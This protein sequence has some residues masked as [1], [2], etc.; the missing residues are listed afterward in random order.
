[1]HVLNVIPLQVNFWYFTIIFFFFYIFQ[2]P[3]LFC[4]FASFFHILQIPEVCSLPV[5]FW[6]INIPC[7]ILYV[8]SVQTFSN[9]SVSCQ[10]VQEQSYRWDQCRRERFIPSGKLSFLSNGNDLWTLSLGNLPC[11]G[12]VEYLFSF[13]EC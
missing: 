7:V 12:K 6:Y 4:M 5:N 9:I 11:L 3:M 2:F 13:S 8:C 10:F 1:M